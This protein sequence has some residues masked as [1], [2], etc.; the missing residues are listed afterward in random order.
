MDSTVG[1]V[2]VTEHIYYSF[3][4]SSKINLIEMLLLYNVSYFPIKISLHPSDKIVNMVLLAIHVTYLT[5]FTILDGYLILKEYAI[6]ISLLSHFVH[7]TDLR[8]KS[9]QLTQIVS[10]NITKFT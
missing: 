5:V 6:L 4:L 8:M 10:A 3:F 1:Y 9:H 7:T 2:Y